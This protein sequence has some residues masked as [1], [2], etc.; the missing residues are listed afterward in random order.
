MSRIIRSV[1]AEIYLDDV[2]EEVTD[3]E[4][5]GECAARGL[6]AEIL[7]E[8]HTAGYRDIADQ[9]FRNEFDL[10]KLRQAIGPAEFDKAVTHD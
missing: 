3:E 9:F 10:G 8:W 6:S 5:E 1:T 4:L 2:L 7:G